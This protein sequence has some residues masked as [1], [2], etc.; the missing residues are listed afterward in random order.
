MR[1]ILTY[2]HLDHL[3]EHPGAATGTTLSF[4]GCPRLD[5]HHLL[6]RLVLVLCQ[7]RT[8]PSSQIL[9]LPIFPSVSPTTNKSFYASGLFVCLLLI[10]FRS[11][12]DHSK[13]GL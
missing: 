8:T 12:M 10:S 6:L 13:S 5:G 2:R 7:W 4:L 11:L 1:P 3:L 9:V